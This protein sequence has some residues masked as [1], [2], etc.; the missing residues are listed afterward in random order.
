M[1]AET[2]ADFMMQFI[3]SIG[4]WGVF[5]LTAIIPLPLEIIMLFAGNL[6]YQG[7]FNLVLISF[8]GTAGC[9]S[10][11]ILYYLL[12]LIGGRPFLQKY[13]KFFFLE[14]KHLELTEKWFRKY[15]DKAVLLLRLV[16]L[17]HALISFPAGVGRY[18][19]KKLV[20][21]S[22]IGYMPWCFGLAYVGYLLGPYWSEIIGIF[23]QLDIVVIAV[24]ILL[25]IY[26]L[27]FRHSASRMD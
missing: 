17:V 12:G 10:S 7:V 22:F 2:L 3:S 6:A 20:F 26:F 16:P 19:F 13:G 11:S 25:G 8:V 23:N 18:G 1:I 27:K 9:A 5:M 14:E 24:L 15:G 21:Y 4:Y